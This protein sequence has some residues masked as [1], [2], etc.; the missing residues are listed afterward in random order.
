[1]CK[2]FIQELVFFAFKHLVTNSSEKLQKL[3]RARTCPSPPPPPCATATPPPP[4]TSP[5][6][7]LPAAPVA[8]AAAA[9]LPWDPTAAAAPPTWIPPSPF[10]SPPLPRSVPGKGP[11]EGGLW[12][13]HS[14][15]NAHAGEGCQRDPPF[16]PLPSEGGG[17]EKRSESEAARP[18][19]Q[20]RQSPCTAHTGKV[21][22]EKGPRLVLKVLSE[23]LE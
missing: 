3:S 19:P 9:A 13:R 1:M 6:P 20:L 15:A 5:P 14:Q 21:P 8:A 7:S 4:P 10:G 18:H 12:R 17:R 16:P 23:A 11:L 22:T 2:L